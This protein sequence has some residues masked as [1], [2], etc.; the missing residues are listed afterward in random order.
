METDLSLDQDI[1]TFSYATSDDSRL[2]RLLIRAIERATGQPHLKRLYLQFHERPGG[3]ET[4][5]QAAVRLL[6]LRIQV[7]AEKLAALPRTGPLMVVANH[8]FGVLDGIVIS[9]LV[10]QVRPDFKILTNAVLNRA[11]EVRRWLLPVDFAESPDALATNLKSRALARDHLVAGGCVIV[12]P[13][14]GIST[15]PKPFYGAA[16]DAPWGN[17]AAGLIHQAKAPVAPFYFAGQNSRLFQIASHVSQTLRISLIFK[18]VHDRIGTDLPI[19]VGDVIPY[20]A[21][22]GLKDRKALMAN[23]RERT[24]GLA[25]TLPVEARRRPRRKRRKA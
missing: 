5:W 6:H 25:E 2:K 20:A 24:Y 9:Y 8:P 23:L 7:N 17:F 15:S 13:A 12:F 3:D 18:E 10:D 1:E 19:R 21:L 14:G 22:E 16:I 11:P 4:F